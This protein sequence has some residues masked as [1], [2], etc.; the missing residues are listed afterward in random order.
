MTTEGGW[1]GKSGQRRIGSWAA[2]ATR[3]DHRRMAARQRP[4]GEDPIPPPR[5]GNF[6][7]PKATIAG[8]KT[9]H[10]RLFGVAVALAAVSGAA[11]VTR[12]SAEVVAIAGSDG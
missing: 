8:M 10:M 6:S 9:H 11:F 12:A 7:L 3:G 5:K 4:W 2:C 1:T